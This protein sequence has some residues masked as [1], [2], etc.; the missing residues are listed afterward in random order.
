MSPD[1]EMKCFQA[2]VCPPVNA[3]IVASVTAEFR[4]R[5]LLVLPLCYGG[6]FAEGSYYGYRIGI[7]ISC[8]NV[9]IV[10]VQTLK[11]TVPYP[12]S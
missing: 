4:Q 1:Q 7:I 10:H 2:S 5:L 3:K 9:S 12:V 8:A 6:L 11:S